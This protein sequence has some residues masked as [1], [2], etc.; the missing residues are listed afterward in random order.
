MDPQDLLDRRHL[1]DIS[2]SSTL[3]MHL[4]APLTSPGEGEQLKAV[5]LHKTVFRGMSFGSM[6][7]Q[8]R[9]GS[10]RSTDLLTQSRYGL[11]IHDT[12]KEE[13]DLVAQAAT[14]RVH[15]TVKRY[16]DEMLEEGVLGDVLAH[17]EADPSTKLVVT[18]YSLGGMLSQI[19]LLHLGE[20]MLQRGLSTKHVLMMGFGSP[21]VGDEGF[22]ARL[23]LLYPNQSCLMNVVYPLD[24]VHA[25]PPASE[26]YVDAVVKVFLR[27][28]GQFVGRRKASRTNYTTPLTWLR[29]FDSKIDEIAHPSA[30]ASGTAGVGEKTSSSPTD[31]LP[32]QPNGTEKCAL[33]GGVGH[34][35][36]RHR[37]RLCTERGS[38]V[39]AACPNKDKG[40]RL[41]GLPDHAT[42]QHVCSVCKLHG[43]R[44]RHCHEMSEVGVAELMS[45]CI[46]HDAKYYALGTLL[47]DPKAVQRM[48]NVPPPPGPDSPPTTQPIRQGRSSSTHRLL[49]ALGG[50]VL[51]LDEEEDAELEERLEALHHI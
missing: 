7:Q 1:D 17:L 9:R 45:Y 47:E 28:P 40:C 31:G 43:H 22:K 10:R 33:C 14:V 49:G 30:A 12:D 44:G 26:G 25:F 15:S 32:H 48:A 38:H 37:C 19:F 4:A 39:S 6:L 24:T 42:G 41:C 2:G 8:T 46:F 23:K 36:N 34:A 50:P 51:L 11:P 35:T 18:G 27:Q 16:F 5:K 13:E 29:V 20:A 21:R 3:S